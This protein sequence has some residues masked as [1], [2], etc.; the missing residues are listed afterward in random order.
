MLHPLVEPGTQHLVSVDPK[1]SY[2][3]S[4][5]NHREMLPSTGIPVE[6][7]T[8]EAK[9]AVHQAQRTMQAQQLVA[10]NQCLSG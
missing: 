1:D 3:N 9:M 8:D 10:F 5:T 6:L 4:A 2:D 7:S